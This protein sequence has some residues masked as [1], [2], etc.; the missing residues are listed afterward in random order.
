MKRQL[1]GSPARPPQVVARSVVRPV[2]PRRRKALR[3]IARRTKPLKRRPLQ[4]DLLLRRLPPEAREVEAQAASHTSY[5]VIMRLFLPQLS[6]SFI[7]SESFT[8]RIRSHFY[9]RRTTTRNVDVLSHREL[10]SAFFV[11]V[12]YVFTFI[13]RLRFVAQANKQSQPD[14]LFARPKLQ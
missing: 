11:F 1:S 4:R 8:P 12:F 13:F 3:S 2:A 7:K 14:E 5:P 9:Y 6:L 10:V